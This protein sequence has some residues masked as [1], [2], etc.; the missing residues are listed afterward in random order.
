MRG[1]NGRLVRTT[2]LWS[3]SERAEPFPSSGVSK[4]FL[5]LIYYVPL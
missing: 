2:T 1:L 5:N 3:N 4:M